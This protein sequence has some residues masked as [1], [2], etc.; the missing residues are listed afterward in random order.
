MRFKKGSKIEVQRKVESHMGSWWPA[1]IIS[2]NGRL[3]HVRYE[4]DQCYRD[5]CT[6]VERVPRKAIRP[7][8]PLMA[9]PLDLASGDI[10]EVFDNGSWKLAEMTRV[11]DG[12]HYFV[13]LLDCC[14]EFEAQRCNL[15]LRQLWHDDQWILIPKDCGKQ[16]GRTFKGEKF[17][18]G[19]KRKSPVL[20]R[21]AK[22]IDG[23]IEK[24]RAVKRRRCEQLVA[25]HSPHLW[26]KVDAVA[27]PCIMQGDNNMHSSLNDRTT[28]FFHMAASRRIPEPSCAEITSSSVG[29]CSVGDSSYRYPIA[30]PVQDFHD[31]WD[32]AE[33]S[34][35]HGRKQPIPSEKLLT[36]QTR[37]FELSAYRS[38]LIALYVSG[39]ISWEQEA[40]MTNLRSVLNISD[41]Q[42]RLELRNLATCAF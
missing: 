29:S 3:Y 31:N 24:Q 16:T 18:P 37:L 14:E 30:D 7:S 4:Y 15:R 36:T 19:M 32:D 39:P 38:T 12:H 22:S 21:P 11:V 33:S 13:R 42:H 26:E 5:K 34:C 9:D 8:P 35:C 40:L 20:S 17:S 6:A 10:L 2:G 1:Q 28:G 23:A 41:D 27:S 25:G